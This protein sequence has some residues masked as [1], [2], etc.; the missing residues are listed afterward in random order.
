M[1]RGASS[2]AD[3]NWACPFDCVS[4]GTGGN[5]RP[6]LLGVHNNRLK[7]HVSPRRCGRLRLDALPLHP[8]APCLLARHSGE[9]PVSEQNSQTRADLGADLQIDSRFC[10]LKPREPRLK[11]GKDSY[12]SRRSLLVF[13]LTLTSRAMKVIST[14]SAVHVCNIQT[15]ARA[16]TQTQA[17]QLL[18][19][20]D[21]SRRTCSGDAICSHCGDRI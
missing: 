17:A 18:P 1:G 11:T 12:S 13:L 8:T 21:S 10:A 4:P 15:Y 20:A 14:M 5:Y 2:G 6:G 7:E 19:A 16:H 3:T 9:L